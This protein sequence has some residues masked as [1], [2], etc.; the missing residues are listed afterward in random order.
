MKLALKSTDLALESVTSSTN[1]IADPAKM[2][3]CWEPIDWRNKE[4]KNNLREIPARS[5]GEIKQRIFPSRVRIGW[6]QRK[7]D[8]CRK[9]DEGERI[10]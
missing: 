10:D 6:R 3:M 4:E 7:E 2:G 1:S 9:K 8:T 5:W